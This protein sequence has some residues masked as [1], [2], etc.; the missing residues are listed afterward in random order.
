MGKGKWMA[1]TFWAKFVTAIFQ[2]L[3]F[4]PAN[5]WLRAEETF[6]APNVRP[7]SP[8][9][10]LVEKTN[11]GISERNKIITEDVLHKGKRQKSQNA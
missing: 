1:G 6:I 2:D 9:K 11:S 10:Q 4:Q 7:G 3:P 8:L 5:G